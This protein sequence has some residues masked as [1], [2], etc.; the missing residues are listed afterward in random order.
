MESPKFNPGKM[1]RQLLAGGI[2]DF[3]H[4]FSS[5]RPI[6]LCCYGLSQTLRLAI[7]SWGWLLARPFLRALDHENVTAMV[8]N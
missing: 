2:R 8:K 4:K 3:F 1:G 5:R 6:S 7:G